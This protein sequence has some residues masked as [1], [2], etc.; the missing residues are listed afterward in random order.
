MGRAARPPLSMAEDKLTLLRPLAHDERSRRAPI[1][2][3]QFM[4]LVL[5]RPRVNYTQGRSAKIDL[6]P[7]GRLPSPAF[8]GKMTVHLPPSRTAPLCDAAS[9]KNEGLSLWIGHEAIY[10]KR[11]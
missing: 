7:N 1:E 3:R 5:A 2:V 11:G 10:I 6:R 4:H 9:P 8:G